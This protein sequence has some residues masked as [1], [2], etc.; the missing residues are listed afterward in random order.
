MPQTCRDR[1]NAQRRRW[2]RP[3]MAGL[4][5]LLA[6]ETRAAS[7]EFVI[8]SAD[9]ARAVRITG[10]ESEEIAVPG[11]V[12]LGS[13]WKL[14]VYA[15]LRDRGTSTPDYL[16]TGGKPAEEVYCCVPGESIDREHALAKS[17][18]LYFAPQRLGLQAAAWKAY[19]RSKNV[20][21]PLWLL[22]LD[23]LR[24]DTSVPVISI[25][26]ALGAIDEQTRQQTM[27]AL[28]RVTLEPRARPLLSHLGA[29][30]R[31]KTWSWRDKAGRRVGGFAGWLADGTPVWLGGAGTSAAVIEQAAPWL[32]AHVPQTV[33]ADDACVNVRFFS[34]YPL[35]EVELNEQPAAAGSLHGR[36]K[37]HFQN[38]RT[39]RFSATGE[40]RLSRASADN[41]NTMHLEGRFG[42][43]EYIARVI[44]REAAGQPVAAARALGVAV[45]TYLARHAD[46]G[47]GCYRIDDDSRTQRV[48]PAPPGR[49][50]RA[51]AQW[52]DGLV[53]NGVA[54]RYH[55]TQSRAQQLSWKQAVSDASAGL[56]WDE[57]LAQAYVNA[58]FGLIG[59]AD[60]GECQPLTSAE[61]WLAARQPSWRV[62][63]ASLPG[64]E[65]PARLPHLC[66][67]MYGNPYADLGRGRIYATGIASA[68]ERLTLAHEYLHF[69]LANHPRGRDEAFVESQ[70]RAL[71]GT[72]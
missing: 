53:L 18:G 9:A 41:G 64:F 59:D 19:W 29:S 46:F 65:A 43:N 22:E 5:L 34:R 68:N 51:A 13:L 58:G 38:G 30:L 60:A 32:V 49:D 6:Q 57:I 72:P 66:R 56:R 70:A 11:K 55:Q 2:F 27:R 20:A 45:R 23:A 48:S 12:P 67:L 16:C 69:G 71:L 17:C 42:L 63:L 50:A 54:G 4:L 61:R 7:V 15:Y 28:Q 25:L 35:R 3:L 52:S 33:P 10:S 24:A 26:S 1:H 31:I 39:L 62:Q 21:V 47:A 40:L 37:A 44:E 36:V 14:F 8:G